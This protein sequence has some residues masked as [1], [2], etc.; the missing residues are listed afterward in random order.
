M[1][2]P[3][4]CPGNSSASALDA[5]TTALAEIVLSDPASMPKAGD[6]EE[7]RRMTTKNNM[8]RGC[9]SSLWLLG[10]SLSISRDGVG[11]GM[12]VGSD[13]QEGLE[14]M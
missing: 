14:A 8:T 10:L 2:I 11:I 1:V 6:R 12:V 5:N 3:R 9:S 13:P 4:C 7:S